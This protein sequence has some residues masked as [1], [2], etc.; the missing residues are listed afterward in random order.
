MA[1][2]EC[3]SENRSELSRVFF[4]LNLV[5]Q[6][7]QKQE[8]TAEDQLRQDFVNE[9]LDYQLLLN[10]GKTEIVHEN[11]TQNHSDGQHIGR[12]TLSLKPVNELE[13]LVNSL[14]YFLENP[15]Q[16]TLIFEPSD[17]SFE[18]I[19]ERGHAGSFKVYLWVDAGNTKQLSY[20]WDASGIRFIT[21]TNNIIDFKEALEAELSV[22]QGPTTTV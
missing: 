11:S 3:N 15:F 5:H 16:N 12:F 9:W 6:E 20:T 7:E 8:L 2:L 21:D 13:K 4:E 1:R 19:I 18:L 10:I 17:P 22:I 14:T